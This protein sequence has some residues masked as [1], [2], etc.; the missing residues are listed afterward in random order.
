MSFCA[1]RCFQRFKMPAFQHFSLWLV[2]LSLL[3]T[4]CSGQRKQTNSQP[5][6]RAPAQSLDLR[7][8]MRLGAEAI[9]RRLDPAQEY[10]PWF[11]IRGSNNIPC[12]PEHASWDLGDM[13]G[14]YLESLI[15]AR[16]MG[17]WSPELSQ[18]EAHLQ[19]FLFKILGHDGLV[20][21]P[22][23]G[24]I[25]HSFSQ[26]SA[27]FGLFAC[28]EDSG[29]PAVR[30]AIERLISG[31]LKRV[32]QRGDLLIDPSVKLEQS[33]GSHLAGYQIYPVIRFYEL[34]GYGD[35]L[36]LAEGLTGW[37][38]EDPVLG[39]SG[40]ITKPLSWEGHIHSWLE[41]MAGCVR[42]ARNSSRLDR[43]KTIAR[44][45]G[46]YDWIQRS[47]GSSF[48]WIATYPT[49]GSSET[50]AISSAIRLTLELAACGFPE[51][52]DDVERFVRNQVIAAQFKDLSWYTNVPGGPQKGVVT[53]LLLGCFDSQSMPNGH[54]GTRGG[55]DV[56]TV[57]GCCLNG[58]MRALFLAWDSIQQ[59]DE[60]G[61]TVNFALTR[62][63]PACDVIG[64]Q[65]QE[66][67]V[68]MITRVPGSVRVRLPSWVHKDRVS[69]TLDNKPVAW[70]FAAPF[71]VL[72]F[73]DRGHRVSVRYPLREGQEEVICGGQQFNIHWRGDVVIGVDPP[74]KGE[75]TCS[76]DRRDTREPCPPPAP[77][78]YYIQ[79]AARLAGMS[80][81]ARLDL[82][83]GGQPFFRIYPFSY[84][85]RAEHEKWDDGDMAGRYVE[86]LIYSR[87]M[88]SLSLD[89][90]ET[91]L[92]NYFAGLFDASDG[93]CYTR[94]AS[95]TPRRACLFS[96]SSAMLGLLAWYNETG[97]PQARELLDRHANG[98]MRIAASWG[99]GVCFPKYEFD[100]KNY[101]DEPAGKDAPI[102]YGGR[103]ILPLVQYWQITGREE[104]KAFLQKSI[105][106]CT[107]TSH[108]IQPDGA[109]EAGEGWWGHLHGTMDMVTGIVEYGR[110]ANRP[111]LVAWGKRVY[112]WIGRTHT[113]RYG[114]VADVSGG[115]ICESCAIASRFRLGLALY[116]AGVVDPFGEIDRH[117][118]NQLLENQFV[119]VS[120]MSPPQ[121][122]KPRTDRT[123]YA[124]VD[125]MIRGTFQCWGTANDLI[126]NDDI[127]G[128]GA[129]GG[130]QGLKLAW[131]A[132]SEWR[133]VPGG[134][135]VRVHLLFNRALRAKPEPPFT[136]AAPIAATLWSELPYAGHVR[137]TANQPINRLALR[138]P[139]GSDLTRVRLRCSS[140]QAEFPAQL[141]GQYA[142]VTQIAAGDSVELLFPLK[143]YETTER[144]A[145]V[146]Y[147]VSWKGSSVL[148]ISP[149][150]KRVPLYSD[151]GKILTDKAPCSQPR[152]PL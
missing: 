29:D 137:V 141:E 130:V 146:D 47:N 64:Y 11:L 96:Q 33:S 88:T 14:R 123:V 90:R 102:W 87:R 4:S 9:A 110:L 122:Q 68:D 24:A 77:D 55:E 147:T 17:I 48:G 27:L 135:E 5:G 127:E 84:P 74:G 15:Q 134:P 121:P 52:L 42:T 35:A 148:N 49:G 143:T 113:T 85:P 117:L 66:G 21:D 16:H 105:R 18:A 73:V 62:S 131:D 136:T 98:V 3:L 129:G 1:F 125:R 133:E 128:C 80:M 28:F 51:Y 138:L 56:G 25:D 67:R 140:K 100:G 76:A 109:V 124:G 99:E 119:D 108:F 36:T 50:C 41:T 107:E 150:G 81:L 71:V 58:G 120:F 116:R 2:C 86:A 19:K 10:R 26:G 63:G 72:P 93:L 152:Y 78:T 40:E 149:A 92:R 44:A 31:Q 32:E 145:G 82:Q 118:R 69:V 101:I 30:V 111:E 53:P 38:L 144:A 95:W 13:T 75:P 54:L 57:E 132:Q 45:R 12:I 83:R 97:S 103:L 23:S 126:G 106:H 65:P 59:S 46:L 61:V 94:E 79:D 104:V 34:T 7:Q 139:D 37:A 114:W 8:P 112:E 60:N 89:P 91:L 70:E 39:P 43:Q 115:R 22:Q 151:R 6:A 142:V 20:H